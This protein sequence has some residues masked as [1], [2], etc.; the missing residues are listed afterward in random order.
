MI[1]D[2][3]E[4]NSTS[5]CIILNPL[6]NYWNIQLSLETA[7]LM[8]EVSNSVYWL[9]IIP[10]RFEFNEIN[11]TDFLNQKKFERV[12]KKIKKILKD[13]EIIQKE[14]ICDLSNVEMNFINYKTRKDLEVIEYKG[15]KIGNILSAAISG[16]LMEYNFSVTE[17]FELINKYYAQLIEMFDIL[18]KELNDI[19]PDVVVVPNDRIM[20]SGVLLQLAK[21]LNVNTYVVYWG[22]SSKK[23]FFYKNSL[24]SKL[25]WQNQ[26][27]NKKSSRKLSVYR[28]IIFAIFLLYTR[29]RGLRTSKAYRQQKVLSI[30]QKYKDKLT[31]TFFTGTKW[32]HSGVSENELE[33]FDSQESAVEYLLKTLDSA[34]WQIIVRHHPRKKGQSNRFETELWENCRKFTNFT[35]I[36][37]EDESDSYQ[38]LKESSIVAIYNSTIGYESIIMG[39]PTV[40]FGNPYWRNSQWRNQINPVD[41]EK[42]IRLKSTYQVPRDDIYKIWIFNS[43]YGKKFKYIKGQGIHLIYRGSPI[44]FDSF[45]SF[46]RSILGKIKSYIQSVILKVL[47]YLRIMKKSIKE[48]I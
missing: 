44:F 48:C 47:E 37:P 29:K 35:E 11:P 13:K 46:L 42:I 41:N 8:R 31:L 25:T 26:I 38:I 4:I 15:V 36:L 32:E 21:K 1:G 20:G 19:N 3:P 24:Y 34:K 28:K 12:S 23:I 40:I 45:F 14:Y 22:K 27:Y 17:N 16:K 2:F 43:S 6:F 7:L 30:K 9:N 39:K 5:K 10:D 18:E 33:H